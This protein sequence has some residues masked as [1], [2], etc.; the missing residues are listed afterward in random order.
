MRPGQLQQTGPLQD[1]AELYEVD[2]GSAEELAQALQASG[3]D[4][5]FHLAAQASVPQS[6]KDPKSTYET[7]VLGQLSLLEAVRGLATQPRV[8]VVSSNEVY[9]APTGPEALPITE[10]DPLRPNNPYAVSKA[11][12]D[13]MGYQYFAAYS[14]SIVRVRPFNHIGPGQSDAFVVSAFARQIAEVEAGLKQPII[15]VGNLEAMRDFTDVR[16]IARGYY[17]ALTKGAPGEVYNLGSGKAVS[18]Q[19]LLDFF[20]AHSTAKVRVERDPSRYRPVDVPCIYGDSSKVQRA[21]R[22]RPVIPLEQTLM[23]VLEYWRTYVRTPGPTRDSN[24]TA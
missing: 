9:G 21:T 1:R 12:Q 24:G 13:M 17:G 15:Q 14:L 22:W 3:P 23:D 18:I 6:W 11:A 7:N 4:L 16:D 2:I 8:L 19:S 5:V 10:A 20:L